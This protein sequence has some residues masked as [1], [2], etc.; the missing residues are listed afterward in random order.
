GIP[1]NAPVLL[2]TG[3]HP[4]LRGAWLRQFLG[5]A[6][7]CGADAVVG[8]VDWQ[9]VKQRFPDNRRTRYR[10]SDAGVCGTNLFYF[11][12]ARGRRIAEVWRKFESDRKRPWKIVARL[13]WWNLLRYRLG[14]L[15]LGQALAA[16]SK[17]FG[18]RL[19]AVLIDDPLACVDVDSAHDL[20]LVTG[21]LANRP[22]NAE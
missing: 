20:E 13:G 8:L 17:R 9:R 15:E 3:D 11:S 19:D 5:R 18:I 14:R 4:L 16:L 6:E 2:C 7:R 1:L 21:L 10:F 12:N 22:G